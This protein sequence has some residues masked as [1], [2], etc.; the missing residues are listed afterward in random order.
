MAETPFVFRFLSF[1]NNSFRKVRNTFWFSSWLVL[2]CAPSLVPFR[3]GHFPKP[4][5][6][7]VQDVSPTSLRVR[8]FQLGLVSEEI[9][10]PLLLPFLPVALVVVL[11]LASPFH[12]DSRGEDITAFNDSLSVVQA[13]AASAPISLTNSSSNC[14]PAIGFKTPS[15]VPR[16]LEGWWCDPDT[17]YAFVGFSYEITACEFALFDRIVPLQLTRCAGQPLSQLQNEF[18]DI[19]N[20]F[21]SRYVRLYGFCDNDGFYDDVVTAAW[22]NSLGV[23][24][25]I[26]VSRHVRWTLS[27]DAHLI[28]GQ[29]WL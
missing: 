8:R 17:E 15:N 28:R 29:V 25:L 5:T 2:S 22:D 4:G 20:R 13:A 6:I 9:M 3:I 16:S 12:P 21:H 1:V 7:N 27:L 26:W 23:H 10:F 19:R 11:V 18:S 14:F 24:A